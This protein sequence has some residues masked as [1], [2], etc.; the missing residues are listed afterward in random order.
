MK[1]KS[2]MF[3]LFFVLVY[4]VF[5]PGDSFGGSSP[6]TNPS[7]RHVFSVKIDDKPLYRLSY[8][9]QTMRMGYSREAHL[10][11]LTLLKSGQVLVV[12][13]RTGKIIKTISEVLKPLD[14]TFDWKKKNIL[15]T[16][17]DSREFHVIPLE[18]P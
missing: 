7:V 4:R 2:G 11:F 14:A 10:I 8:P 15:V 9:M 16:E 5:S 17:S 3:S 12:D 6:L 18:N 1:F 13:S